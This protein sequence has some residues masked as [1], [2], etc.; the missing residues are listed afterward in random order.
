MQTLILQERGGKKGVP[1]L[2]V[3]P[4]DIN[5]CKGQLHLLPASIFVS[6]VRYLDED[7]E[8]PGD[9]TASHQHKH[10]CEI[11]VAIFQAYTL[12]FPF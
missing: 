12:K 1:Y 4:P 3:L 6:L 9:D 7:E 11:N 10:A 5:R 2:Q 8:D